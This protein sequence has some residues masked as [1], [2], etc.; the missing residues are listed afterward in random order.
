M[1]LLPKY[2]LMITLLAMRSL[3][4]GV[5]QTGPMSYWVDESCLRNQHFT[6]AFD[7]FRDIARNL[8][9]KF[10]D[11]DNFRRLYFPRLY[12]SQDSSTYPWAINNLLSLFCAKL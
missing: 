1:K 2:L 11:F 4:W 5:N 9:R 7:E 6:T 10:G 8:T 3:T 12:M